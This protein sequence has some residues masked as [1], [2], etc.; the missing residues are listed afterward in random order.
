MV[1]LVRFDV[2]PQQPMKVCTS[3]GRFLK[4]LTLG[5]LFDRFTRFTVATRK[6]PQAGMVQFWFVVSMLKQ[7]R[8]V[9]PQE[10]NGCHVRQGSPPIHDAMGYQDAVVRTTTWWVSAIPS[11]NAAY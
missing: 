9:V 8:I 1:A 5:T 6:N 3:I 2:T 7:H 10:R 4:E 11:S